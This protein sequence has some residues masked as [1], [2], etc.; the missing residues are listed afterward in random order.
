MRS[1]RVYDRDLLTVQLSERNLVTL[2]KTQREKIEEIKKKTNYYST[3]TLIERY[4]QGAPAPETPL[5]RRVPTQGPPGTP[6]ATPQ[7]RAAPTPQPPKLVTPQ[8]PAQISANLQ[9]QLSRTC[10]LFFICHSQVMLKARSRR[11][12][13]H[14]LSGQFRRHASN[15]MTSSPT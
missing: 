10:S 13:Q 11:S 15:G 2:R 12:M 5:R 3:R 1:A 4:D 14:H 7:Q 9:Q 6:F 8:T